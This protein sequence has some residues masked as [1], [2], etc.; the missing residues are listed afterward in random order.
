MTL[1]FTSNLIPD[2]FPP[3]VELADVSGG[4]VTYKPAI[5]GNLISTPPNFSLS[6][7]PNAPGL[8]VVRLKR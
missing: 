8:Y 2:P 6:V 3:V 4:T 1:N 7:H 5:Q